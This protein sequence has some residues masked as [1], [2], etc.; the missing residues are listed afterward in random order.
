MSKR[1]LIHTILSIATG[2]AAVAAG[3]CLIVACVGIW[4]SGE[5]VF[6]R[7][8][9]S[10][11][12][13]P[14]SIPVYLCLALV[15]AGWAVS[16]FLPVEGKKVIARHPLMQLHRARAMADLSSCEESVMV[17]ILQ[18]QKLAQ[19]WR[20]FTAVV[21]TLAALAFLGYAVNPG[22]YSTEDV[23]GSVRQAVIV[24]LPCAA[25]A[26]ASSLASNIFILR[27][28]EAER[29]LL[30]QVAKKQTASTKETKTLWLPIAQTVI[31]VLA[32]SMIVYGA[33]NG[34]TTDVLAKA[35]NICT[36]C[37]GLG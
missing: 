7:E 12:F 17:Q 31:A 9:V 3:L 11:A 28:A 29:A 32:I 27:A 19:R 14:I 6:S 5:G 20:C 2:I 10:S 30:K 23:T 16:V 36:E 24:L 25:A 13:S 33:I 1:N 8:A 4:G 34:G 15:L 37:V 18:Q 26:F 22:H 35:V 21:C